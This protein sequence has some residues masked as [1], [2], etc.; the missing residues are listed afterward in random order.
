MVFTLPAFTFQKFIA[1]QNKEREFSVLIIFLKPYTI[2]FKHFF[3]RQPSRSEGIN[4]TVN[5]LGGILG[6][7]MS[8]GTTCDE[9]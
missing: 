1:I 6:R 4:I 9:E 8:T 2:P 3:E 5:I 7:H